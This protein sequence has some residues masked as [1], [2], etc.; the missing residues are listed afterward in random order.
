MIGGFLAYGLCLVAGG[1]FYFFYPGYL[2]FYTLAL[3]LCLPVISLLLTLPQRRRYTLTVSSS[4]LGVDRGEDAA[5]RFFLRGPAGTLRLTYR[6]DNLLFP[7]DNCRRKALS[8]TAGKILEE[9]LPT[10][11]CGWRKVTVE[12]CALTDWLGLFSLSIPLPQPVMVLVRPQEILLPPHLDFSPKPGTPLRAK[13]GGGPG[14]DYEL[15][16]Y[17]PGD[18]IHAI[19]W[20]LTAKQ[21]DGEPVLRETLEPVLPHLAVTYPHFGP[22]DTLENTLDALYSLARSLVD[23]ERPFTL[24]WP[25]PSTAA[26]TY[27]EVDCPAAW[28][29]C[30]HAILAKEAPL[31]G[32]SVRPLSTLPG[33]TGAV[34]WVLLGEEVDAP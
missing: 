12:R 28:D 1:V 30:L 17:Q 27:Y 21:P 9:E 24:C 29:T 32:R 34:R 13:P 6:V 16:P 20:K 14:E 31:T 23:M 5:L 7:G 11:R 3:L 18:P 2:S 33:H 10:S 26:F 4:A 22:E 19:H 8:L 15:R 25:E